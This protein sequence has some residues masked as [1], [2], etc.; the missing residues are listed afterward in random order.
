MIGTLQKKFVKTAMIAI[1]VLLTVIVLAT[2]LLYTFRVLSDEKWMAQRIA[3]S[4]GFPFEDKGQ[5]EEKR[6]DGHRERS[7]FDRRRDISPD[8]AMAVRFFIVRFDENGEIVETD[9]DRIYSVTEDEAQDMAREAAASGRMSGLREEFLFTVSG[10]D[11]A[12]TVVFIDISAQI[13]SVLSVIGILMIIAAVCWIFMLL[14]VSALSRRVIAP[15]AENMARQKQFVTNAGHELKTP[16]AIIMANTEALEL[17]NGESKWTKNIK[18]QTVRLSGLMQ[19]LLT[20]SK[21]DEADLKL[22]LAEVDIGELIG[23]VAASFEEPA[24]RKNIRFEAEAPHM[25]ALA[26]KDSMGQLFAILFDNAVKYTPEGGEISLDVGSDKKHVIVKLKNTL[27]PSGT[28]EDPERLFDR[29]YRK[30]KAR[31]QKSGGYGI[32]LSAAR[33][34]AAAN[35]AEIRAEYENKDFIAFTVSLSRF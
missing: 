32:G 35:K 17:Y 27:D 2:G 16:L 4:G 34:I 6:D 7:V 3:E 15:I 29:F 30:D 12:K 10:D 13:S 21:M 9:T 14:L 28:R 20:L 5:P 1:T 23:E 22:P 24:K 25:S 11:L 26:N 31:T 8:D 19:N 33:A 18:S